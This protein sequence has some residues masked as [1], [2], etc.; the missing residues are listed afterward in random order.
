MFKNDFFIKG[1]LI[2]LAFNAIM[3]GIVWV[4]VE[5]VGVTLIK[6]PTKLYLLAAI[7]AI[8]LMWYG[9]KKKGCMK[10]G[11]GILLSVIVAVAAAFSF[12]TLNGTTI[13]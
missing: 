5:K 9:M 6:N 11:I 12:A 2:G 13:F 3:V 7:P 10:M 1:F 8:L 4:L